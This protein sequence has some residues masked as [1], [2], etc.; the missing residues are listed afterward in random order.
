MPGSSSESAYDTPPRSTKVRR[1]MLAEE[2]AAGFG[3]GKYDEALV[4]AVGAAL[5]TAPALKDPADATPIFHILDDETEI[6]FRVAD[7]S[8]EDAKTIA[9]FV[10]GE[11]M[12]GQLVQLGVDEGGSPSTHLHF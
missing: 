8:A 6:D 2:A 9:K 5:G 3:G 10:T 11:H 4:S 7:T 1:I 12:L